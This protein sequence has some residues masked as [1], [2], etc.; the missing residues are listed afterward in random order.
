MNTF[1]VQQI[2]AD[3]PI[4]SRE[5]RPGVPLIY[6]DSTATAQKPRSVLEAMER[7]Y[8]ENYANIHRGIYVLSEESTEMYEA[9]R[10]EVARFIGA[11]SPREVIFTRNATESINLVAQSWGRATLQK[12]D[13]IL[14]SEMEHHSNL[15]PWQMLAAE[16]DLILDFIPL[17]D[18]GLL[19]MDA[20][21]SLLQRC[22]YRL[23]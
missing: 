5:V 19:D 18:E 17:T 22:W 23:M 15:V 3:F 2:R 21:A 6:L 10:A 4:L 14:L 20:Y 12:G 13:R 1:D 16:K 11:K 7:F 9:A 8:R